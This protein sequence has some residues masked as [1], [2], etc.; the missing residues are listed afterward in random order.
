MGPVCRPTVMAIPRIGTSQ[1]N[2][3]LT[4]PN[5]Q[6]SAALWYHDHAMGINRLNI[7]AGLFGGLSFATASKT[8][9]ILP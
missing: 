2:R 1:E 6:E 3:G 7:Y 5:Q 8:S 9:S 4:H